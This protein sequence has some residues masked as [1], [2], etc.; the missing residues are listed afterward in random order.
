MRYAEGMDYVFVNGVAVI[1][2]GV[3][4]NTKP[5]RLLRRESQQD[6]ATG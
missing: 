5:G 2:E 6:A 4:S 3:M 1:D